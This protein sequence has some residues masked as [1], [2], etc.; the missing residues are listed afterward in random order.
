MAI[1]LAA[2]ASGL[3]ATAI[4]LAAPSSGLDQVFFCHGYVVQ[5]IKT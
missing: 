4:R 2:P 1:G 3:A 5:E